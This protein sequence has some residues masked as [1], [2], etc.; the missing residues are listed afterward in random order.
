MILKLKAHYFIV[1]VITLL[2]SY[3]HVMRR[4]DRLGSD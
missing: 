4:E 2:Y 3:C 1:I